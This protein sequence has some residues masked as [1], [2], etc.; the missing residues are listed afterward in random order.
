MMPEIPGLPP[1]TR[2]KIQEQQE[3]QGPMVT[4]TIVTSIKSESVPADTWTIPKDYKNQPSPFQGMQ[5]A[6]AAAPAPPSAS[7]TPPAPSAWAQKPRD[8]AANGPSPK[9]S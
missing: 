1:E 9:P 3:K 6:P 4:K 7:A 2:K 5:G 8:K